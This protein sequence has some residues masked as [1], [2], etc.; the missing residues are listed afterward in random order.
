[1]AARQ[2]TAAH[3]LLEHW[4]SGEKGPV[5]KEVDGVKITKEIRD[6]AKTACDEVHKLI[7][8]AKGAD[9][10][11]EYVV[12]ARQASRELWGT[13]DIILDAQ[14]GLWVIDF[15]NGIGV[16]VE[17]ED[18]PQLSIYGLGAL[19]D[20]GRGRDLLLVIIQPRA[21]SGRTVKVQ[22]ILAADLEEWERKWVDRI[23]KAIDKI[24]MFRALPTGQRFS[25]GDHCRWC[26]GAH[27]CP[28]IIEQMVVSTAI[29]A[30]AKV[31]DLSS[32]AL[33]EIFAHKKQIEDVLKLSEQYAINQAT[34]GRPPV[35]Y[36]LVNK[37]T[38]RKWLDEKKVI[39]A[40]GE[41]GL[42]VN[43]LTVEKLKS[44]S[45]IEKAAG[46]KFVD[47]HT[48]KSS[49]GYTLAPEDDKRAAIEISMADDFEDETDGD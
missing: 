39:E 25:P 13:A 9:V 17:V 49:P 42:D 24:G 36:K 26:P 28:A 12:T 7:D 11:T 5:P 32:V 3:A 18:N 37:T 44:I 21:R 35:G 1:M 30:S 4:V 14:N 23:K 40:L 38:R 41:K 43:E 48:V 16:E 10:Y 15:K 34:Q 33:F 19:A 45:I 20:F 27:M 2:G 47:T 6:S 22:T 29:D 31:Q 8:L 46:K